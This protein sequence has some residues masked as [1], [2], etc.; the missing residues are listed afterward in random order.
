MRAR[1]LITLLVTIAAASAG[2]Q[3][4]AITP[5]QGYVVECGE[6]FVTL[7]G[8][9]LTGTASTLV[10]FAGNSQLYELEPSVATPTSLQVWIPLE[11]A[12]NA[13]TY[14]VTVKATDTG[15]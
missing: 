8:T 15:S 7:T 12:Y 9:N 14:S 3:T 6:T 5:Q 11:V 4:L 1:L 10:D 2:A 13:G